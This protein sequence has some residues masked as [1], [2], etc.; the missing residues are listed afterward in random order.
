[1]LQCELQRAEYITSESMISSID[2]GTFAVPSQTDSTT[3][4]VVNTSLGTTGLLG[5]D[6]HVIAV[7]MYE[8][9]ICIPVKGQ[10]RSLR[11]GPFNRLCM[12]SY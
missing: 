9:Q 2:D 5:G 8:L 12:V 6:Q 4:Y 3:T 11:V 1:M 7:S 10:S